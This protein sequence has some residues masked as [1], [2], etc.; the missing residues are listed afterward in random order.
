MSEQS[1][2]KLEPLEQTVLEYTLPPH[3]LKKNEIAKLINRST[4]T[5][6]RIQQFLVE[7]GFLE[8][9]PSGHI[10]K[11]GYERSTKAYEE[12]ENKTFKERPTVKKWQER[13]RSRKIVD[14][15][16]RIT[17]LWKLCKTI[18]KNPEELL[19]DINLVQPLWD[20]FVNKFREG[21]AFSIR[22]EGNKS[23][24]LNP[25]HYGDALKSY[26][27][28]NG[29]DTPKGYIETEQVNTGIYARIKLSDGEFEQARQ[30]ILQKY[31][32]EMHNLFVWHH[33]L[34]PR[35]DSLFTIQVSF[36]RHVTLID[37]QECEYYKCLV[38]EQKQKKTYE[39]PV[40][41]EI[42]RTLAKNFGNARQ[43][44][45][46][47]NIQEIK[48]KYNAI[49]RE[50]FA[51]LGRISPEKQTQDSYRNGTQE[52]YLVNEPTHAIRHS[53]VHWLMRNTGMRR[54]VVASFFWERPDTLEIYAE[55]TLEEILEQHICNYCNPPKTY[56]PNIIRFCT[57][58]HALVW[59]N[60]HKTKEEL[61][62]NNNVL[63]KHISLIDSK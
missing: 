20:E 54:D 43:L 55:S 17:N 40:I 37:N 27:E 2:T 11:S 3:K 52:W 51:Y 24:G 1:E 25:K 18:D 56:D 41:S 62:L 42:A 63:N 28:A 48:I 26:R 49:L 38:Y 35:S 57:L 19:S 21:S 10:F 31:G 23:G 6:W 30:Y 13:M 53:C 45:S 61:S 47:T 50:T 7:K 46:A 59:H 58:S 33:E 39:K 8:K 36:E 44:H 5:V 34:G 14:Y 60:Y 9:A 15:K 22:N 12:I 29:K 16:R 4:S 32:E